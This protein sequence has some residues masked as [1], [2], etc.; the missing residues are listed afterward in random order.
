MEEKNDSQ[1]EPPVMWV[2]MGSIYG[3]MLE[4]LTLF[5]W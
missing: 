5:L 2:L 3:E 4:T 1:P